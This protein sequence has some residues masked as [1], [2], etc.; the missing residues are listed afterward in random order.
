[1]ISKLGRISRIILIIAKKYF[2]F[3]PSLILQG[4]IIVKTSKYMR[5]YWLWRFKFIASAGHTRF[6][7]PKSDQNRREQQNTI[8]ARCSF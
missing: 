3:S 8:I 6:Y 5:I 2:P 7:G 4:V 1:M